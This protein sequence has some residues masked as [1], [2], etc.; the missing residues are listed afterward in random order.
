MILLF[1][2]SLFRY[3]FDQLLGWDIGSRYFPEG[4]V[5]EWGFGKPHF[6][7]CY[8]Q[9]FFFCGVLGGEGNQFGDGLISIFNDDLFALAS[10]SDIS[11]QMFLEFGDVYAAHEVSLVAILAMFRSSS[12]R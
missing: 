3:Q 12:W 10:V 11:A 9:Q 4:F 5:V 8:E 1:L 7:S 6:A 2:V